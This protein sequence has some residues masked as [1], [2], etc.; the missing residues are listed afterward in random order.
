[1]M[2]ST[3]NKSSINID[4][5]ILRSF[6]PDRLDV[7]KSYW[8]YLKESGDDP[9]STTLI[10]LLEMYLYYRASK[11][12]T[13]IT[14]NDQL[15]IID[16]CESLRQ[17]SPAFDSTSAE[18]IIYGLVLTADWRR[19]L[20]ILD[21]IQISSKPSS[22]SAVIQ[23]ALQEQDEH[24]VWKLIE[25]IDKMLT[26]HKFIYNCSTATVSKQGT[27]QSCRKRLRDI[28]ITDDEF[29]NLSNHFFD[30]IFIEENIFNKSTPGELKSFI[31]F[32]DETGPY[33]CVIDGLNV[34]YCNQTFNPI[35]QSKL[36]W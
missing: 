16:I 23:R 17:K 5:T 12:G 7:G 2:L 30:K 35:A 13:A 1:M 3:A 26:F 6:F 25:N 10:V 34:G 28:D 20:E 11:T 27:C 8:K 19:S 31:A 4:A 22:D 24:L 15:D 33:H 9:K 14:G 29:K 36:V 21:S 32:F 18:G